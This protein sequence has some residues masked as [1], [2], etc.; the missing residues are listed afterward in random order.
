MEQVGANT[1]PHEME[2]VMY[3]VNGL[4]GTHLGGATGDR[5]IRP[6]GRD[7]GYRLAVS[8][9]RRIVDQEGNYTGFFIG[10]RTGMEILHSDGR[11]SGLVLGGPL[12]LV[13]KKV[14]VPNSRKRFGG[15][16]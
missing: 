1:V 10:G 2:V 4:G 9:G 5:F 11:P 8:S 12:G 7:S 14:S 16:P 15:K 3:R 6:N 13:V